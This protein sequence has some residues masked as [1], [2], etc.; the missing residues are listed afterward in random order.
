M[1]LVIALNKGRVLQ[2]C[3]PILAACGVE[4]VEHPLE[5]RKLDIRQPLRQPQTHRDPIC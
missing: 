5:S 2:E 3:L 4:P 1:G